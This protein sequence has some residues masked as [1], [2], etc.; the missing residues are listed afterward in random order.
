MRRLYLNSTDEED[1]IL[2]LSKMAFYTAAG[3][4]DSAVIIGEEALSRAKK[5]KFVPGVASSMNSI[6][7]ACFKKGQN[8][9]AVELIQSAIKLYLPAND[10]ENLLTAYLNLSS[11]YIRQENYSEALKYLRQAL[12]YEDKYP[13]NAAL[14][15]IY[16]NLGIVYR[17]LQEYD[18]AVTYFKRSIQ[19]NLKNRNITLAAD[20]KIGL[21]ILYQQTGQASA[22]LEEIRGAYDLY[23]QDGNLHGMSMAYENEGDIYYAQ[24]QYL[25][26][27][28]AYEKARHGYA[29]SG[30]TADLA[31]ISMNIA[32]VQVALR[33]YDR[34]VENLTSGL[35]NAKK[36]GATNYELDI[37]RQF[38]ELYERMDD[39][40]LALRYYKSAQELKDSVKSDEQAA[41]LNRIRTEFEAAQKDQQ[42]ALLDADKEMQKAKTFRN[43][44][45]AL[46]FVVIAL[47][48]AVVMFVRSKLFRKEKQLI[49]HE[50]LMAEQQQRD[51]EQKFL[52]SQMN[53]H[54]IFNCM[55]TIESF[56]LQNKKEEASGLIQNFSKI[57]R[58]VLEHSA[59]KEVSV[60]EDLNLIKVYLQIEQ[61]RFSGIFDFDIR[62]NEAVL[63]CRMAPMIIQPFV[64]NAIVHG[65]RNRKEPGG[66]ISISAEPE[67]GFIRFCIKDNGVGRKAAELI[68]KR[69]TAVHRSRAIEIT[70]NRL[71]AIHNNQNAGDYLRY[72]DGDSTG[73]GTQVE[74]WVPRIA[75]R[76]ENDLCSEPL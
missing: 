29:E 12:V 69:Q 70:R 49:S 75:P 51:A 8:D 34:A 43:L 16:K 66:F 61:R 58:L 5:I 40:E 46:L 36:S 7:W 1:R 62:V 18:Q 39:F 20:T 56:V 19:I 54:F 37:L 13:M 25:Q 14:V 28:G 42:I 30:N 60:A 22:A 17:E 73:T 24:G 68:K 55:N 57:F 67:D 2:H 35:G 45:I 26:A 3:N 27:L 76:K 74:I 64:E 10:D 38:A 41:Q 48:L 65:I 50:K 72:S 53:P 21:G 4:P 6:G 15:A 33:Q 9:K 23:K 11:I 59:S 63:D 47:F 71:A 52:R 31:Y 44:V 32:R